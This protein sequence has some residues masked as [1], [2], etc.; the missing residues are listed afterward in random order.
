VNPWPGSLRFQTY[1]PSKFI[2][3]RILVYIVC[4][5]ATGYIGNME[6][7]TTEGEKPEENI[8][9]LVETDLEPWHHVYQG[10]YYNNFDI[11]EQSGPIRGF[12]SHWLTHLKS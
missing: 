7:Y 6:I 2:E 3:Y 4:E 9:S 10:N 11:A 8:F 12:Q 5:A 1:N